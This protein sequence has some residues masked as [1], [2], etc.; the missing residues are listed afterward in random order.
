MYI[1]FIPNTHTHTFYSTHTHTIYCTHTP[2]TTCIVHT[3][4]YLPKKHPYRHLTLIHKVTQLHLNIFLP[5]SFTRFVFSFL[6]RVVFSIPKFSQFG[7]LNV[8]SY[9]TLTLKHYLNLINNI[10]KVFV[11]QQRWQYLFNLSR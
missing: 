3:S 11:N 9:I 10:V 4:L 1:T 7:T 6:H 2:H 5:F 8:I